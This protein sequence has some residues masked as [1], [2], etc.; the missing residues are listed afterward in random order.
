MAQY[1][2]A[3]PHATVID[4]QKV[5]WAYHE[6]LATLGGPGALSS[7]REGQR[8]RLFERRLADRFDAVLVTGPDDAARVAELRSKPGVHVAP[9]TVD[10]AFVRPEP[11]TT[12]IEHVLLYGGSTIVPT[13]M[14]TAATSRAS[15]LSCAS[16]C[17]GC[18]RWSSVPATIPRFRGTT[19]ASSG[20]VSSRTSARS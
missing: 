18:A 9:I 4:R 7:F 12:A 15:G 11:R 19:R 2:G 5:E 14:P 3:W 17:P 13:P 8:F 10:A 1:L 20:A 16:G 6:Q